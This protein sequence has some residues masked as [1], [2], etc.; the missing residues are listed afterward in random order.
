MKITKSFKTFGG[1]T[2]F[3]EHASESTATPM[4]FSWFI[5]SGPPKGC[6]LWLSGLTCT[7]ENFITKAGAQ[8]Y[9]EEH[10]LMV[11]CP[12]TSPRGL[13]LPAEHEAYDFGS[14]AGFY[15]DAT[16]PGYRDHYR[17]ESYINELSALVAKNHDIGDR[18]AISGHSM[19]GHG[20]LTLGLKHP[21]QFRSISA[22]SPIVHPSE[23]AWGQKA[24]RGYLGQD[25]DRSV[26]KDHDATELLLSG[27]RHTAPLLIDQGTADEF[28]EKQ[29]LTD[30]LVAAAKAMGQKLEVQMRDG[31]DHSYYFIA[32]FVENH[33][34][35]H[36]RHLA[37]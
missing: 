34:R 36:A 30:H 4:K 3:L 22:F 8:K 28:L 5:P 13:N 27:K 15:I 18:F 24:F 10:Q 21:T 12:D 16:V 20:A 25:T 17:M 2:Q 23:S 29:L 11:V 37:Q 7:E 1:V 6:I 33:I 9:L 32:T 26:W 31:Y 35:F 14:G 19:G